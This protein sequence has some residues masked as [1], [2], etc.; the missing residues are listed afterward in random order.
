[1]DRKR[2]SVLTEEE[3][4]STI[5]SRGQVL[6]IISKLHATTS[7]FL[8][9]TYFKIFKITTGPIYEKFQ[10]RFNHII[11]NNS[12]KVI[13]EL[14]I[15]VFAQKAQEILAENLSATTYVSCIFPYNLKLEPC[16]IYVQYFNPSSGIEHRLLGYIP[17]PLGLG[18]LLTQHG[19]VQKLVGYCGDFLYTDP[20]F[21][22]NKSDHFSSLCL[23]SGN[24]IKYLPYSEGFVPRVFDILIDYLPENLSESLSR[25]G[26]TFLGMSSK[27][28]FSQSFV[29]EYKNWLSSNR[30]LHILSSNYTKFVVEHLDMI[31]SY[32]EP[33]QCLPRSI[34]VLLCNVLQ[35][36]LLVFMRELYLKVDEIKLSDNCAVMYYF[37]L[38][39]IRDL[40]KLY[41]DS[42]YIPPKALACLNNEI[43]FLVENHVLD[44]TKGKSDIDNLLKEIIS[45]TRTCFTRAINY[46]NPLLEQFTSFE[47]FSWILLKES[48]VDKN[49]IHQTYHLIKDENCTDCP[50]LF[51]E[52]NELNLVL[53][54]MPLL[55]MEGTI[56]LKWV[57]VLKN[58][59][60]ISKIT[61]LLE[62]LLALPASYDLMK[63]S[64]SN[65]E[66]LRTRAMIK[67]NMASVPSDLI[68]NNIEE[69][70][71]GH[72]ITAKNIIKN[73]QIPL[74]ID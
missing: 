42:H 71:E 60:N 54:K 33:F 36:F 41:E 55:E 39:Q 22:N 57:A 25:L 28:Q 73:N 14:T 50:T 16:P 2:T 67:F 56:A 61:K 20:G 5:Y 72:V 34:E 31:K 23:L 7:E 9:L 59:S 10:R 70:F 65:C 51:Q 48:S 18:T 4:E 3:E 49:Q 45:I 24:S 30:R 64:K 21:S 69:F 40:L 19:V 12:E 29:S 63:D 32:L 8:I 15:T 26:E 35:R 47:A 38:V 46:I 44:Q 74:L 43:D 68:L 1:M 11:F 66:Y 37:Q 27:S 6:E 17:T 53:S 13:K 58:C 52:V 62:F